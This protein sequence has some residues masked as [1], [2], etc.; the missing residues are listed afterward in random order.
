[1][2]PSN[3]NAGDPP[4]R[5][6]LVKNALERTIGADPSQSVTRYDP[7]PPCR[8]VVHVRKQSDRNVGTVQLASQGLLIARLLVLT[9]TLA[10]TRMRVRTTHTK[11]GHHV[12]PPPCGRVDGV[13]DLASL[14]ADYAL[15]GCPLLTAVLRV[16]VRPT[17]RGGASS[18]TSAHAFACCGELVELSGDRFLLPGQIS[19]GISPLRRINNGRLSTSHSTTVEPGSTLYQRQRQVFRVRSTPVLG[20]SSAPTV[21]EVTGPA[22]VPSILIAGGFRRAARLR[23][24]DPLPLTQIREHLPASRIRFGFLELDPRAP[25]PSGLSWSSGTLIKT[26]RPRAC[27]CGFN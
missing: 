7:D 2:F 3:G 18:R 22:P 10:P 1:M 8:L 23:E 6:V 24:M 5:I 17:R 21:G 12:G 14:S 11:C 16:L 15:F 25:R 27:N 9:Q 19:K 26:P 20:S 4:R 13:L